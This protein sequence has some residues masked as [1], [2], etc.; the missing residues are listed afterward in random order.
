LSHAAVPMSIAAQNFVQHLE[1]VINDFLD[2]Q[3]SP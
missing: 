2:R 3:P 1:V